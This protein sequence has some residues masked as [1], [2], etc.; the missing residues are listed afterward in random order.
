MITL[1]GNKEKDLFKSIQDKLDKLTVSYQMKFTK[2][3]PY[4][5]DGNLEVKGEDKINSYL[6]ELESELIQWYYCA[7]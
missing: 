1:I 7:C 4:L 6:E 2:N 5:Q 3:T